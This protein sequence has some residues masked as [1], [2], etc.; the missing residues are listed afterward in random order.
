MNRRNNRTRSKTRKLDKR[1]QGGWVP[2]TKNNE[3]YYESQNPLLSQWN[4][5]LNTN[6]PYYNNKNKFINK[7]NGLPNLWKRGVTKQKQVYYQKINGTNQK[8]YFNRP[9]NNGTPRKIHGVKRE[10]AAPTAATPTAAAPAAAAPTAAE[11]KIIKNALD[12]ISAKQQAAQQQAAQAAQQQAA[13]QQAAEAAA[14]AAE[15]AAQA[16]LIKPL[17]ATTVLRVINGQKEEIKQIKKYEDYKKIDDMI[18]VLKKKINKFNPIPKELNTAIN[19]L[20]E[21]YDNY[22]L[23]ILNSILNS[24]ENKISKDIYK[25]IIGIRYKNGFIQN[26]FDNIKSIT[27]DTIKINELKTRYNAI[28][29]Y[30]ET[31]D[32]EKF[33]KIEENFNKNTQNIIDKWLPKIKDI[34]YIKTNKEN[35]AKDMATIQIHRQDIIDIANDVYTSDYLR[36]KLKEL[37]ERGIDDKLSEYVIKAINSQLSIN[38]YYVGDTFPKPPSTK[39]NIIDAIKLEPKDTDNTTYSEK[40]AKFNTD[41]KSTVIKW[42]LLFNN[43]GIKN[44][45]EYVRKN[46]DE[47][48]TDIGK[49]KQYIDDIKELINKNDT[50]DYLKNRLNYLLDISI[51]NKLEQQINYIQSRDGALSGFAGGKTRYSKP[52]STPRTRR[53]KQRKSTSRKIKTG[54]A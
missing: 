3:D 50:S 11:Q 49:I 2:K 40:K 7:P 25:D 35:F 19:E 9:A 5:P 1:Q 16:A 54:K 29:T 26:V 6:K 51:Y 44:Y 8:I 13:Q 17:D 12:I 46:K 4:A 37:V 18:S 41:I 10:A 31:L 22:F 34:T 27:V 43:V 36:T 39:K 33:N 47:Y 23:Y 38:S 52:K 45:M 15:A 21:L 20:Q 28:N 32:N 48:N 30:I 53:S 42:E 24:I 14:K